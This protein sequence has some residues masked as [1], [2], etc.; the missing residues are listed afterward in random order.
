MIIL[1]DMELIVNNPDAAKCKIIAEI[2][3]KNAFERVNWRLHP[4]MNSKEFKKNILCLKDE[5]KSFKIGR[6][7]KVSILKWRMSTTDEGLIPLSLN[8]WADADSSGTLTITA[9]YTNQY[10]SSELKNVIITI[11]ST[12]EPEM[13]KCDGDYQYSKKDKELSWILGNI[14]NDDTGS[15]EYTVDDMDNEDLYPISIHFEIDQT[16][17][18]I[19]IKSVNN[20]DESTNFEY[21]VKNCC[22]ADKYQ[23][24]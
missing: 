10:E 23:I 9:E 7:S 3:R 24:Q 11:P 8:F 1:G 22:I 5:N 15:I 2:P 17:S 20:I 12:N 13:S 21:S 4:R 14:N 19:D 6:S 16:Y 18:N